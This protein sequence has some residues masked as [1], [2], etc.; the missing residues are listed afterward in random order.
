MGWTIH[1][2]EK[3]QIVTNYFTKPQCRYKQAPIPLFVN[4]G[5]PNVTHFGL[6]G[7]I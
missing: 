1:Y 7:P 4:H 6:N 3:M 2:P 5:Q